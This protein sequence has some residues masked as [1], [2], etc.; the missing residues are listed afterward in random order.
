MRK[1]SYMLGTLLSKSLSMEHFN[2]T[3]FFYEEKLCQKYSD[4]LL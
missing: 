2:R 3:V 4:H 1:A